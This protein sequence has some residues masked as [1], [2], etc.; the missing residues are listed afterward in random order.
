MRRCVKCILPETFPGISFNQ[1]GVCN[2]CQ[3][4]KGEDN[5]AKQREIY[6]AKFENLLAKQRGRAEFDCLMSY[7]GGKDSTYTLDILVNKYHLRVLA[8]TFDNGF[9]SEFAF[10]NIRAVLEGLN[11]DH[12]L[13]RPRFDLLK[14]VFRASAEGSLYPKKTLDRASTICT[15][16]IGIIKSIALKLAI[17]RRI[18]FIAAGWSPGQA[19][20]TSSMYRMNPQ[21][22]RLMQRVIF[23]PLH[24]V[25][26]DDIRPYFLRDE[27]YVDPKAFP[28]NVAP[29][30]FLGYDEQRIFHRIRELGWRK[31]QDTD[32]NSTN[33]LLNSFANKVHRDRYG[34]HPYV[35]ELANLVREGYLD[36]EEALKR[37]TA[38]ENEQMVELVERKLA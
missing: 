18:P 15:S 13:V 32:P 16:C 7:S 36:R 17:E 33:C 10:Q 34:Y 4:F 24:R 8:F 29:L 31:P 25:A 27:D 5:L 21:M 9:L 28:Y 22:V 3:A 12:L 14:R 37:V 26:G 38:P 11:A 1:E 2:F 35:F 23:A 19:P 20:I 6:R 30:A